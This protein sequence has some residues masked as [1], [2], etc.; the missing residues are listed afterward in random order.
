MNNRKA[1]RREEK[2]LRKVSF[3]TGKNIV[4][5]VVVDCL[6]GINMK[7]FKLS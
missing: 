5:T 1:K 3:T 7:S 4:S 2:K 6:P